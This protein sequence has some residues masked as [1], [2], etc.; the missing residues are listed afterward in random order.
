MLF[1]YED[2]AMND[3]RNY[4]ALAMEIAAT[5]KAWEMNYKEKLD[6][7]YYYG[8]NPVIAKIDGTVGVM[9]HKQVA[10]RL[11]ERGIGLVLRRTIFENNAVSRKTFVEH[12]VE[13]YK[14]ADPQYVL[15][16][17]ILKAFALKGNNELPI[18]MRSG[19][20]I[21]LGEEII[22]STVDECIVWF[23]NNKD[24]KKFLFDMVRRKDVIDADNLDEV[25][26]EPT[27]QVSVMEDKKNEQEIREEAKKL[28]VELWWHPN[29]IEDV[30]RRLIE[31]RPIWKEAE[32]FGLL[33][34]IEG[35]KKPSLEK[36]QS[37]I[38]EKKKE[39]QEAV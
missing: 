15:K 9:D 34:K 31:A 4:K 12:F 17:N 23:N 36:I 18:L 39:L 19:N 14:P 26:D 7:M 21:S 29:K 28:K 13:D 2:L 25:I 32:N 1:E 11:G 35:M 30:E 37:L 27:P 16:T 38:A 8:E 6:V 3:K 33:P 20:I 24:K 5:N 10:I 22:G